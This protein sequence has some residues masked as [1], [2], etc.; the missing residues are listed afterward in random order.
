[1]N[2]LQRCRTQGLRLLGEPPVDVGGA[3]V[4]RTVLGDV[5]D[6]DPSSFASATSRTTLNAAVTLSISSASI[7][8]SPA[9]TRRP[10]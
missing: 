9:V 3:P 6:P 1:M 4:L 5:P 8:R 2:H 7:T 10:I